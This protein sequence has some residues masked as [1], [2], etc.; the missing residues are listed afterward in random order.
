MTGELGD[1]GVATIAKAKNAFG[2]GSGTADKNSGAV[3]TLS[4]TRILFGAIFLFD[5]ILKWVLFQQGTMQGVIQGFNI[6]LLSNNWVLVGAIVGVG[7]MAVGLGLIAGLFQRPAAIGGAVIMTSIWAL[8]GYGGWGQPGYTDLGGDL[9]LGIVY[10]V[11]VFVPCAHGLASRWHLRERW[12]TG[13]TRDRV[14]R[15]LVA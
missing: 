11:L 9:M 13:S 12:S 4:A 14:L 3:R 2:F 5:G 8:S 15:F 10:A 7:E 1:M 6:D